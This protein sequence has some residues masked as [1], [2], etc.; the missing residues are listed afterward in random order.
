MPDRE[1]YVRIEGATLWTVRGGTGPALVFCHG[2]PGLWDYLA[3]VAAMLDDIVTVHRFDQRAC[4]RSV[5]VPPYD[6]V[7]A[8]TDLDALRAHWGI[9]D[10]IV[11]GHSWGATLALMYAL[12]HPEHTR[13]LVYVSGTGID[14]E[15]R[16]E[17]GTNRDARL[18]VQGQEH[19]AALQAAQASATGEEYNALEREGAVLVWA[20]DFSDPMQGQQLA[21]TLFVDGL[22]I[23]NEVNRLLWADARRVVEALDMR[24]KLSHLR[25][26]TLILHGEDDPRPA[27]AAMHLASFVSEADLTILP[28]TG[29]LPWLEQPAA[30]ANALRAFIG[31]VLHQ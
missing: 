5:G 1:E 27:W 12:T 13:A 21:P 7:T 29:H 19:L 8:L 22:Q 9:S 24:E 4:G 20:T 30:F 28:H 2:G 3:P 16:G 11:A 14:P 10:W 6:V 23:N 26:P 17:Y 25:T 31:R 15:W 18:G